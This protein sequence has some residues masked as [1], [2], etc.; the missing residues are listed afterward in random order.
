MARG[1]GT[2]IHEVKELLQQYKKFA[3]MVKKMGSIKGLF[4]VIVV[5]LYS[6]I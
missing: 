5:G 4:K 6:H 3:D 2:S 1:S